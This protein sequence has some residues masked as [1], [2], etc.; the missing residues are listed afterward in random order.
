MINQKNSILGH[1]KNETAKHHEIAEQ[2]NLAKYIID[3]SITTDQYKELLRKNYSV[4]F[5]L[6]NYLNKNENLLDIDLRKF[7]TYEKSDALRKD[8]QTFS[9]DF[10]TITNKDITLPKNFGS[11]VGSLYVIEGSMLGGLL[12]T[13]H[14]KK[15]SNLDIHTTHHFFGGNPEYHVTRWKKFCK[16]IENRSYTQDEINTSVNAA[17]KVFESFY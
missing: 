4:Y 17:V 13:K 5:S 9:I 1:L 10:N 12:I 7:V 8:L 2:K 6:E 15:C 11:L 16:T 3:H 14:L